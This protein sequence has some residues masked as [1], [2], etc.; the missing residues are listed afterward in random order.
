MTHNHKNT[1]SWCSQ[2]LH[3]RHKGIAH[4]VSIMMLHKCFWCDWYNRQCHNNIVYIV[5]R[6]QSLP[7]SW[8]PILARDLD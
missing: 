4:S 6:A 5:G 8:T 1:L 3:V 2:S 7:K